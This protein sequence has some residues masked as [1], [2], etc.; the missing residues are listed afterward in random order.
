MLEITIDNCQKFDLET[1]IGPNNSQ[2]FWINRRD[3][4]IESKRNWQAIFDKCK[5]SSRQKYRK[6]LTPNITFQPNKIFVRNDLFEKIIKSCKTTNLEFLKLK[7]KLGLCL[8]EDI[9]DK[10]ELIS[11]SEEIFKEE[12]IITQH[13][14]GNEQLKEENEQ[15]RKNKVVKDATIKESIEKPIEIK[16]PQEDKNRT[17][18]YPN[19]FDRKKFKKILG[20][21]ASNISNYKN[22]I[23]EFKYIN[24]RGLVN[25]I[26]NNTISEKYLL[27]KV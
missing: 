26:W 12:K 24:I 7:E 19:W 13:D 3:L 18:N 17:D 27:K 4:E 5:D 15:L 8:Y 1:I 16:S 23:G 10:Q 2:D 22:E 20:T 21:I 14:V 9:C 11:M 6:E 25:N